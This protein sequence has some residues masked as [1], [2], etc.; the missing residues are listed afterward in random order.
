MEITLFVD[1]LFALSHTF[2]VH[3]VRAL[4]ER[5][6][7]ITVVVFKPPKHKVHKE[8]LEDVKNVRIIYIPD[9]T[10]PLFRRVF[11]W[12]FTL[13]KA[14]AKSPKDLRRFWALTR[15]HG[16]LRR[17]WYY[18]R[19]LKFLGLVGLR[20]DIYHFEFGEL[21]ARYLDYLE[22]FARPCVVSFRG[23][24]ILIYPHTNEALKLSYQKVMKHAD[25]IHCT[26][27][28]VASQA[29]RFGDRRKIFVNY[30]SIDASFFR[31]SSAIERDPNL[32]VTVGNLKWVKGL[33]Y[34]LLAIAR[35]VPDF[36]HLRYVIVGDG[37]TRAQLLFY[38]AD[39]GIRDHV[40]FYGR[41]TADEVKGLLAKASV[42]LL[43]SLSEGV[44]N[45]ALEAMAMQV[46][47]VTTAAGGMPEAIDDRV[48]GYVVPR[49]DPAAIAAK[50]TLLLRNKG[51]RKRMG[52]NAR[53]RV[54]RDFT[55]ERQ[56]EV[57]L[58]EYYALVGFE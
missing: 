2:I 20:S 4:A 27:E 18:V 29:A 43:S 33:T 56:T 5:G 41:A 13:A 40:E 15:K 1:H 51:L 47:V 46:P 54:L 35:V 26:S 19:K 11:V 38:V 45:A 48:E 58:E 42:Y 10:G 17:R 39:L 49:Y 50:V 25:R 55:I 30:P 36:P 23:S 37:P 57:F 32:I 53:Q 12:V 9:D 52:E 34:A 14:L 21:A 28:A 31:P 22:E 8:L 7:R 44:S 6:E 16:S 24:D 3:K